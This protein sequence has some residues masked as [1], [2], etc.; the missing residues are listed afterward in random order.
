MQFPLMSQQKWLQWILKRS[1]EKRSTADLDTK[2]SIKKKTEQAIDVL[3]RFV[4]FLI[5]FRKGSFQWK[6]N[7]NMRRVVIMTSKQ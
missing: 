7:D 2:K 6:T 4:Y 1:K 3:F 5:S